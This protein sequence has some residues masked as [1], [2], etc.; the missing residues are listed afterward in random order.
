MQVGASDA[1]AEDAVVECGFGLSESGLSVDDFESSGFAG[2]VT[3]AGEVEAF[4][5][6]VDAGA[7]RGDLVG[8]DVG[9]VVELFE[10]GDELALRGGEG[11]LR[12]FLAELGLADAV[13]R[14]EP[15]PQGEVDRGGGGVAEVVNAVRSADS[16]LRGVDAVGVV[17][18]ERRKVAGA[19]I[20]VSSEVERSCAECGP[21]KNDPRRPRSGP[22]P[23]A[24]PQAGEAEQC[25]GKIS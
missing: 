8:G 12:G 16:E 18:A 15:V 19:R 23:R 11:G 2:G 24:A 9:L 4:A 5:G 3:H 25:F 20:R 7:E 14:R 1:A 17:E 21:A 10:L 6:G 22:S 13:L